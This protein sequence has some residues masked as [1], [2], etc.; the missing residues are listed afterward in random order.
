MHD[1]LTTE[2]G[3]LSNQL[4]EQLHRYYPQVLKLSS[5]VDEPWIWDLLAR[6]PT[7]ADARRLRPKQVAAILKARRIRRVAADQVVARLQEPALTVA[8]IP[9]APV[10]SRLRSARCVSLILYLRISA[11]RP[12]KRAG[13]LTVFTR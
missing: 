10:M 3:R 8:P 13:R 5:A 1:E 4:W 6:V 9:P 7:P 11:R 12:T 2:L